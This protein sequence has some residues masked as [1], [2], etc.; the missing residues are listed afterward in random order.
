MA[1]T[2]SIPIPPRPLPRQWPWPQTVISKN[3]YPNQYF[4]QGPYGR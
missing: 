2:N 4:P 1:A 3:P